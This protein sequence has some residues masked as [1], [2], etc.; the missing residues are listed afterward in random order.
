[1]KLRAGYRPHGAA[2]AVPVRS[3]RYD[4]QRNRIIVVIDHDCHTE[5]RVIERLDAPVTAPQDQRSSMSET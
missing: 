2:E 4:E 1:M 3:I 5:I